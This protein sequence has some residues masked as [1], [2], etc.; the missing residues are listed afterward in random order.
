MTDPAAAR[1]RLA[2]LRAEF[3]T[4]RSHRIRG[5]RIPEALWIAATEVA[6]ALGSNRVAYALQLDPVA[7]RARVDRAARETPPLTFVE[8]ARGR[9]GD[10][11]PLGATAPAVARD[12]SASYAV[13]IAD[14]GGRR[15]RVE[16]ASGA[17]GALAMAM[18]RELWGLAR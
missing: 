14:A 9:D 10:T 6:S 4:W 3:T 15:L 8:L 5:T 17:N 13:E 11:A 2:Q 18:A 12:V 7:L 16:L 1:A